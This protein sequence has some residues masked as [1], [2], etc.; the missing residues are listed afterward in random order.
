MDWFEQFDGY[1]ERT[2]FSYWSEP[3]NAVTNL[4]FIIA[5]LIMWRRVGPN[6]A[7]RVLCAILF[8]IGVGSYLFHT[9]ATGWAALTDIAPIGAFILVYLFLVNRH[10]LSWPLWAAVL[11]TAAFIPYAALVVPILDTLPFFRISNFYW[12]VPTLLVL[13]AIPLRQRRPTL[14]RG[15]LIGAAILTASITLRSVDELLCPTIPIGTHFLWH[16]LNATMLGYMIHVYATHVLAK[17]NDP[18]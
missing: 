10:L 5:A 13:Y 12:T 1:C 16:C 15:F 3:I 17:R 2:D 18:R 4:A 11:G 7:A 9:H 6:P 8:M 14:S